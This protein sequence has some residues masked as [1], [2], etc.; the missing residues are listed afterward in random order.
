MIPASRPGAPF[1]VLPVQSGPPQRQVPYGLERSSETIAPGTSAG[2]RWVPEMS[3]RSICQT[4]RTPRLGDSLTGRGEIN[5]VEQRHV[6][7][8]S[9]GAFE[10]AAGGRSLRDGR[11]DLQEAVPDREDDVCQAELAHP[12]IAE[13]L[14]QPERLPEHLGDRLELT[15]DEHRLTKSHPQQLIGHTRRLPGRGR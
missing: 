4:I 11:Y 15:G 7:A 1:P 2:C 5:E 9:P 12:R 6:A 13:R 3:G 10:L 14:L 8:V